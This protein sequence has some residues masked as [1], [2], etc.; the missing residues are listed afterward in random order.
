MIVD[1]AMQWSESEGENL[2]GLSVN[3]LKAA[4]TGSIVGLTVNQLVA[5]T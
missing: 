1:G 5:K 2:L 3:T 4:E